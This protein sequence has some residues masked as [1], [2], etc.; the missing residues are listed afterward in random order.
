MLGEPGGEW[1]DLMVVLPRVD[2]AARMDAWGRDDV[3][4]VTSCVDALRDLAGGVTDTEGVGLP[5]VVVA[6]LAGDCGA[7]DGD[8][9]AGCCCERCERAVLVLVDDEYV[10]CP[11]RDV[12][13]GPA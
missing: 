12:R 5:E 9:L 8:W 3:A 7:G 11:D 6:A 10:A 4:A 13:L 2:G 1:R